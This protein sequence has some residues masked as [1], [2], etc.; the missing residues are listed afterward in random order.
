M[1]CG[2]NAKMHRL[3][4][5]DEDAE[6]LFVDAATVLARA[7]VPTEIVAAL[8]LGRLIAVRKPFEGSHHGTHTFQ[9]YRLIARTRDPCREAG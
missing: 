2:Y 9:G 1:S 5:D 3:V 8:A 4:F 6:P 7:R